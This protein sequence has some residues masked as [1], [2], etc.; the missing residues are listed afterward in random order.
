M[1]LQIRKLSHA[2]GAEIVGADLRRPLDERMFDE[3][4]RAFL[5]HHV[6][7]FRGQELTRSQFVAFA[8][9]WGETDDMSV[10][11]HSRAQAKAD[12]EARQMDP[13]FPEIFLNTNRPRNGWLKGFG[14]YA[15]IWHADRM[16]TTTPG[17]ASMLRSI[18]IP[19][20]GGD[21]QFSNLQLAYETLSDGMKRLL[22]GLHGIHTGG[23]RAVFDESDPERLEERRRANLPV[24]HP[25]VRVHPETGRKGLYIAEKVAQFADMTQE[26]SRPLLR[27]LCDHAVRP[28][29]VYRHQWQK[30]D[31]LIWD[32]RCTLHMAVNDYDRSQPRIMERICVKGQPSGYI[33]DTPLP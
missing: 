6:I 3:V 23:E 14:V 26:E 15:E 11:S 16:H 22:D 18:E 21:T 20:V 9:R 25:I 1:T 29:F 4:H 32:N 7:L 2:L 13:E 31:L 24:A 30:D 12:Q 17:M 10:A 8:R 28:Q 19:D 33:V 27:Y 5:Q